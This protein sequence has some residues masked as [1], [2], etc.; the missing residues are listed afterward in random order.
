V[1]PPPPWGTPYNGIYREAPP[2]RGYL[3]LASGRYVKEKR[4][5]ISQV[6]VYKRLGK[7]I[8]QVFKRAFN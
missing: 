1:P 6:E 8:I 4:V 2:E 7:S 3:F 5:A